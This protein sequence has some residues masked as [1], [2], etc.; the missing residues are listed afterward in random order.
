MQ[1]QTFFYASSFFY[2]LVENV[3]KHESILLRLRQKIIQTFMSKI[4]QFRQ[5]IVKTDNIFEKLT[6]EKN[7]TTTIEN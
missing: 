4:I 5:M 7:S 1:T 3:K 6:N 2:A